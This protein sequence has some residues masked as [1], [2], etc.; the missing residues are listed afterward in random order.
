MIRKSDAL[1]IGLVAQ[2]TGLIARFGVPS[3]APALP[4]QDATDIHP[5][6][7]APLYRALRIGLDCSLHWG[8]ARRLISDFRENRPEV[9][10][11]IADVD[12]VGAGVNLLDDDL[13]AAILVQ[14][15]VPR[16]LRSTELWSERLIAAVPDGHRLTG[17][18]AVVV[19]DLRQE[20]ILLAGAASAHAGLQDAIVRALGGTVVFTRQPVN[21]DTLFDLV[22]LK[23]GVTI[24]P[25]A[26]TGAFYPGVTFRPICPAAHV[27]YQLLW[28]PDSRNPALHEFTRFARTALQTGS[29]SHDRGENCT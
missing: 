1:L 10:L 22:A 5:Q 9:E 19:A 16:G 2:P 25:G 21:R 24:V 27:T 29:G 26:S 11:T 8:Q 12:E 6:R 18:N 15:A 4:P 3:G 17:H 13:D 7:A 23:F 28:R 14:G 20:E